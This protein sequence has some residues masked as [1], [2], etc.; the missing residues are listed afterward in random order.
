MDGLGGGETKVVMSNPVR[1]VTVHGESITPKV[2]VVNEAGRLFE[3]DSENGTL[4]PTT[5]FV[6]M[7][8]SNQT[9]EAAVPVIKDERRDRLLQYRSVLPSHF[10]GM[11]V[12]RDFGR[13]GVF[14]GTITGV[15][16]ERDSGGK[17]G[18]R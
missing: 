4:S 3:P 10:V 15:E 2:A 18:W 5:T 9:P 16:K 6:R 1:G 8:Q 13:H 17:G 12:W 11:P 14:K 7:V